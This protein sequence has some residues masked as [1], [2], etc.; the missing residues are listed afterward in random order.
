MSGAASSRGGLTRRGFLKG[1]G[2]AAGALGLAGAAG[3]TT[4]DAWLAPTKAHAESEER[5]GY[6]FHNRH[7]QC[8]CHLK[9]TVRDGRLVLV[10]PNSW[11]DKRNETICL[12]GIAEIQHVYSPERLQS[13]LKR[14]GERGSG[15]FVE[16]TWD[17]ALDIMVDEYKKA[18]KKYGKVGICTMPSVDALKINMNKYIGGQVSPTEGIDLGYGN[19]F[20][21]AIA[22]S[23]K[24]G[25]ASNE[26]KDWKNAKVVLNVG[27][28]LLE[29]CMVAARYFYEAKEAGTEIITVD[30]SYCT[31]A[32]KSTRW[33]PIIPGTDAALYL[34]MI[35][36]ILENE[37]YDKE[38]LE[39]YTSM[40]FLVKMADGSLLRK[41][42]TSD[43]D[44]D[45]G[46]NP[47]MMVDSDTGKVVEY[48]AS[49][50]TPLL[51]ASVTIDGDEYQTVFARL[52]ENQRPYTLAWAAEKTGI[53]EETLFELAEKYA[54]G[55]PSI[56]SFG[57]GGGEKFNNSDISG[58]S[59]VVLATLVGSFGSGIPGRG[60][61]AYVNAYQK[62]FGSAVL[63]DWPLPSE[64]KTTSAP[65]ESADFRD[66]NSGI[67]WL[68]ISGAGLT[69][70]VAN[71]E[72]TN[73]WIRSLDFVVVQ[74]IYHTPDVDWADIVLPVCSHFETENEIGF[75]RAFRGHALLQMKILDPLFQS[76]SDFWIETEFAKRLGY[77]D[78]A[79]KS[80]EEVV[81]YQLDHAA[82]EAIK[83]IS[84]DDLV[85]NNGVVSL[86]NQVEI[87]RKY[88]DHTFSTSSGRIDLYYES[89]AS[90]NQALPTWESASEAYEGN[91]LLEKYPLTILQRRTKYHIHGSFSAS[92][93][94]HQFNKP[95]VEMNPADAEMRGLAS[96]DMVE[97]FNDRGS[98]S[99]ECVLSSSIRPGTVVVIEGVWKKYL[100]SGSIQNVT[101]DYITPRWKIL[102][103]GRVTGF[104][105]TLVEVKKA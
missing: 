45:G 92:T 40:P 12:K 60:A 69:Q 101:N 2:V 72:R 39:R 66:E 83:G 82:D 19:G 89:R 52:K 102:P 15:E 41:R 56:L 96:G 74:E 20:S 24:Q 43:S 3:M 58:H 51:D 80:L 31:T 7:C 11:P 68:H 18:V 21:P 48:R 85:E 28:N 6:T 61:G 38:Y 105:D 78:V 47:F 23:G 42:P 62:V 55:G 64:F 75:L 103:S 54:C 36:V 70:H 79:P 86:N 76:H 22:E 49:G 35:S 32:E 50:V 99:C 34:G 91:P 104:N 65:K 25:A 67:H 77:G 44:Q 95:Q 1:A 63:P 37:W 16:I 94:M 29:T 84:L 4:T 46:E 17:E 97:V 13:P 30:P 14:V 10:E 90:F 26:I 73:E 100:T 27:C 33:I 5:V 98:F 93:W 71:Q 81:R 8:N 57:F 9:C 59:A 88:G 53:D 87:A